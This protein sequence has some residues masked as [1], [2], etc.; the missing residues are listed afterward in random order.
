MSFFSGT[1][2]HQLDGKNRIRI[3][4]KFRAELG[5][6]IVFMAGEE[7]CVFVYPK[8]ALDER[9]AALGHI[10]MNNHAAMLALRKIQSA[11]EN[12]TEDEQGRAMLSASLREH[13]GA[14]KE[15]RELVTIGM[16]DHLEIWLKSTFDE[17]TNS[18]S[19]ND[20]Y[21]LVGF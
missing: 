3:P 11:V 13:I 16:N 20:A 12:V 8:K 14:T 1:V 17:Y 21:A 9:F 19:F 5:E 7:K 10:G 6:D 2:S 4:A 18:I 15:E